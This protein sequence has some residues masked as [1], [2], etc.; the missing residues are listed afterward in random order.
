MAAVVAGVV[1]LAGIAAVTVGLVALGGYFIFVPTTEDNATGDAIA[2]VAELQFALWLQ[3]SLS[4]CDEA[5]AHL[6]AQY[7]AA[8]GCEDKCDRNAW[9]A[10][11]I[12]YTVENAGVG[13]FPR[14]CRHFDY[15]TKIRDNPSSYGCKAR[16]LDSETV[17]QLKK[18]DI[19]CR[20]EGTNCNIDFDQ[21][22]QASA[23]CDIVT[24]TDA[25]SITAIGGNR[26]GPGSV[27]ND[28]G[29]TVNR[30]AVQKA[31]LT[32]A[33][34]F[35]FITCTQGGSSPQ[36][37]N[38]LVFRTPLELPGAKVGDA[39]SHQFPAPTGGKAPHAYRVETRGTAE[40]Q[41]VYQGFTAGLPRGL[42][43]SASGELSG[44]P[45]EDGKWVFWACASDSNSP[46][47][48][49]C[50]PATLVVK[51]GVKFTGSWKGSYTEDFAGPESG[52][53]FSNRGSMTLEL[54]E[55]FS[56][57]M[58]RTN[59]QIRQVVPRTCNLQDVITD[60][61]TFYGSVEDSVLSGSASLKGGNYAPSSRSFTFTLEGDTLK[62]RIFLQG[63]EIGSAELTRQ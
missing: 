46:R 9:S 59:V 30:R 11:F 17:E 15:F 58:T 63:N 19:V 24:A 10:A 38:P 7:F 25:T 5:P 42:S 21:A 62:G 8:G 60:S 20:C 50:K 32:R 18:G 35:G 14:S 2:D 27:N 41:V 54:D 33:P 47:G 52:C 28:H 48:L 13:K 39:Y 49:S 6:I 55:T 36:L 53:Q 26:Y 61:G 23:H 31:T 4:E 51:Q 57:E 44:K 12:S 3:G 43:L 16:P 45:E 29:V 40:T 1:V 56:G 22:G 34:Y 37:R